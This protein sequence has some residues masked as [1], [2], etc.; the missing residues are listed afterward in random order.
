ME[1]EIE[2]ESDEEFEINEEEMNDESSLS[3]EMDK[4][5]K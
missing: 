1:K 3:E 4:N 5:V 2:D